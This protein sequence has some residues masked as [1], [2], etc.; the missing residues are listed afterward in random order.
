MRARLQQLFRIDLRSLAT[1][2][3]ALGV[4]LLV[5]LALRSRDLT[6]HYTDDGMMPRALLLERV[7][8]ARWLSV[9]FLDG[10][11]AWESFL[12]LLAGLFACC[13]S[14]GYRTRLATVGCWLM[15]VS[16]QTRNPLILNGGDVLTRMLLVWS[17]F[18]P[19]GARWSLDARAGRNRYSTNDSS[20]RSMASAAILIQVALMYWMTGYFKYQAWSGSSDVFYQVIGFQS[21]AKPLVHWLLQYPN[22]VAV[23]GYLVLWLEILGPTLVFLPWRTTTI[24]LLMVA[25]FVLLH[26]GIDL[27]LTVG[28]FTYV[29]IA[30]WI[31]FVPS[32]FWN[33]LMRRR[34]QTVTA[35]PSDA[36]TSATATA[37][38]SSWLVNGLVGI[39]LLYS[40]FWNVGTARS[41][42]RRSVTRYTP[43][44]WNDLFLVR[45]RWN[46]FSRPATADGWFVVV[47]RL[48]DGRVVDLLR[49]GQ[50]A[51]WNSFRQPEFIYRRYP[52]HRWR[53]LYRNIAVGRADPFLA[54]LCRFLAAR[55]NSEHADAE[56][57]VQLEIHY[58]QPL[59]REGEA[60]QRHM[61]RILHV[62]SFG[63]ATSNAATSN[64]LVHPLRDA[65]RSSLPNREPTLAWTVQPNE[66]IPARGDPASPAGRVQYE[67]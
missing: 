33:F 47:T 4:L 18:L 8:H 42:W 64:R 49:E 29:S 41:S 22:L 31:L 9:H 23:T 53:K 43:A 48:A 10:S 44:I 2:R 25:A 54:P 65:R 62:E 15:T 61:Q 28:Q 38:W 11:A 45:Q 30:A 21:Y 1:F 20:V 5:D 36:E 6:A 34:P 37:P 13:L 40:V 26:L 66:V 32:P 17:I 55:W 52:N 58:M 51:D 12:F 39:L 7:P 50:P 35:N 16:L 63:A 59:G 3:I 67:P 27:S 14:A 24:R 60:S 46:M 56:R 19:L 57:A